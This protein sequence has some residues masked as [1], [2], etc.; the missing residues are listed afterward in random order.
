MAVHARAVLRDLAVVLGALQHV[1][2]A[3]VQHVAVLAAVGQVAAGEEA[4][5]RQRGDADV[6]QR[7]VVE[8][9]RSRC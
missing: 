5:Q 9:S 3:A 7:P 4:H 2:D 6:R 8:S 1:V